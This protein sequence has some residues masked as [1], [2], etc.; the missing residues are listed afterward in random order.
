[1]LIEL[2]TAILGTLVVGA[3][4]SVFWESL[5][6]WVKQAA[7]KIKNIIKG[8]SYGFKVLVKKVGEGIKEI[9]RHYSKRDNQ[10]EET[11]Q[12]RTVNENDVPDDIK[13]KANNY[14]ETDITK[15]Y[16]MQ[17]QNAS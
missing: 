8:V 10:W 1:M 13:A 7:Q 6:D 17:L 11:T 12:T 16:E 5:I 3:V 2:G 14:E 15:E 4:I 9:I